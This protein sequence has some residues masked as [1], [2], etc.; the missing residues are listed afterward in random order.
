MTRKLFLVTCRYFVFFSAAIIVMASDPGLFTCL[1]MAF[2]F[3]WCCCGVNQCDCCTTRPA[4]VQAV[5]AG[6]QYSTFWNDVCCEAMNG[7]WVLD[8]DTIDCFNFFGASCVPNP[9]GSVVCS[10]RY[11]S[12]HT[13]VHACSIVGGSTDGFI[14]VGLVGNLEGSDCVYYL[15]TDFQGAG[16]TQTAYSYTNTGGADTCTSWSSKHLPFLSSCTGLLVCT[17]DGTDALIT[18]L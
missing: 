11:R 6:V 14:C 10:W 3:P 7:T 17:T 9:G 18:A 16:G 2:S 12:L 1:A 13:P 15:G 8:Y 4:Q 5:I